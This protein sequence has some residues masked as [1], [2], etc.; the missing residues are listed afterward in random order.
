MQN[1]WKYSLLLA[2]SIIIDQLFKGSAQSLVDMPNSFEVLF[3]PFYLIRSRNFYFIFN[4]DLG[5]SKL[6]SNRLSLILILTLLGFAFWWT[7][8][9]RNTRPLAGWSLSL[10]A[11]GL[12]SA[13]MDRYSHGYTLDYLS[14]RFSESDWINF[15]L[16]DIELTLGFLLGLLLFTKR[17]KQL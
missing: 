14:L 16:G 3:E 9:W 11:C 2:F 1:I 7:V 17:T 8:K 13:F 12:F 4:I 15:S 6:W 5:L 10:V